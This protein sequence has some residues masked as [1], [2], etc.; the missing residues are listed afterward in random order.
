MRADPSFVFEEASEERWTADVCGLLF[1]LLRQRLNPRVHAHV[2]SGAALLT[3]TAT[4][5]FA[6]SSS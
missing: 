6:V 4:F 2:S 5:D 1:R 3:V